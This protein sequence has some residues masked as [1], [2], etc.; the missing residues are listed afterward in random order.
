MPPARKAL[1]RIACVVRTKCDF[2]H[3]VTSLLMFMCEGKP[4]A[5]FPSCIFLMK[6]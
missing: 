3:L 6:Y 1:L 4:A 5:G 2:E